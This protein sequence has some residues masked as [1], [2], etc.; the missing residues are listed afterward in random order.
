MYSLFASL[1]THQCFRGEKPGVLSR[2]IY[3][4]LEDLSKI[5]VHVDKHLTLFLRSSSQSFCFSHVGFPVCSLQWLFQ[6]SFAVLRFSCPSTFP[7]L[8]LE[9]VISY[10]L[11]GVSSCSVTPICPEIPASTCFSSFLYLRHSFPSFLPSAFALTSISQNKLRAHLQKIETSRV[12][13]VRKGFSK[14][15]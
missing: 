4:P 3:C 14:Y 11:P 9:M 6:T 10:H 15:L 5:A 1:H 7:P 13:L 12:I 8:F 2:S